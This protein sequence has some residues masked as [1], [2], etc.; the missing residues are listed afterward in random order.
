VTNVNYWQKAQS[1]RRVLQTAALGGIGLAIAGAFGCSEG[2]QQSTAN[3]PEAPQAKRGGTLTR[4]ASGTGVFDVGLDPHIL[5]AAQ[6]GLHG[7]FYQSF[8]R[9]N[10]RTFQVEQEIGQKWEQPSSTE[11]VISIT[12]G[13]KWHNKPPVNGRELTADDVVFTFNRARSEQPRFINRGLLAAAS[14][15]EAVNKSTVRIV[16]SAPDAGLLVNMT[17]FPLRV[18]APEA[19]SQFE[20]R[21]TT[22]ESAI[23]TGAF[24]MQSLDETSADL[25][26]NPDYYKPGLPYLDRVRIVNMPDDNTLWAAF[27]A[28][29]IDVNGNVPGAEAVKVIGDQAQPYNSAWFTDVSFTGGHLNIGRQPFDDPRIGRALKLLI[30]YQQAADDWGATWFGRGYLTQALGAALAEWDFTR[31]EYASKFLAF[32]QPKT[33]ASA[34]AV[35]LLRAAGFDASNPLKF[36]IL[37]V[38]TGF[39]RAGSEILQDQFKRNS[40]GAVDPTIRLVDL[41]TWNAR[42]ANRDFDLFYDGLVAPMPF[43]PDSWFTNFYHTRGSRN[44][45]RY[46]N[47]ALDTLIDRQ[48]AIFDIAERKVLAKEILS[49]IVEETPHQ[50]WSGRY[51]GN[52]WHPHVKDWAPE[53]NSAIWGDH[54]E[55]VWLDV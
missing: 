38:T 7:L 6:V 49:R 36:E 23:G 15:I 8:L 48:R 13:V 25:V 10:A 31:D 27:L 1:R 16:T 43:E 17:A 44:Y 35:S 21:L 40:Q 45:A 28:R 24:I 37:A 19:V 18:L 42:G 46:T 2:Q 11:Y 53:A 30:D 32:R 14:R 34:E 22:A 47:P 54:Y 33:Q 4:R 51:Q 3:V 12:P 39:I 9:L 41:P 20:G 52:A 55:K 50:A 29:Q 26:R 5:T